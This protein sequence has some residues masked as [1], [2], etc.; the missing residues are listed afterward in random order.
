MSYQWIDDHG[1]SRKPRSDTLGE[2]RTDRVTAEKIR[3][4]LR[5]QRP[6]GGA[7]AGAPAGRSGDGAAGAG[8][9]GVAAGVL[10]PAMA[11]CCQTRSSALPA[12]P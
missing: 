10:R 1:R 6:R 7:G 9:A 3:D 4:A 2:R 5:A 11:Y 8:Q 12:Q